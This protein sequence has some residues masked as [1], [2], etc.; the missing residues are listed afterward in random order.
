[1]YCLFNRKKKYS[2]TY[3]LFP[4]PFPNTI[5]G[6]WNKIYQFPLKILQ[7]HLLGFL[8]ASDHITIQQKEIGWNFIKTFFNCTVPQSP[9]RILNGLYLSLLT[10]WQ[11]NNL[12][13]VLNPIWIWFEDHGNQCGKVILN[14][15]SASLIGSK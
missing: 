3:F 14:P 10:Y 11:E 5:F 13:N 4:F 2:K 1:M 9:S 15:L 12:S 8:V 6:V 7:S